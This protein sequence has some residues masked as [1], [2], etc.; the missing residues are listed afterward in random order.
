M[1]SDSQNQETQ[2]KLGLFDAVSIILGIIIGAGIYETPTGIF[3]MMGDPWMTLGLWA[4]C[5]FLALIGAL[6]YAELAT[7]Y[8]RD[9]G[10]YVYITRAYGPLAGYLFGWAQLAVIQT[11]SIGLMAYVFA[12]YASR[13]YKLDELLGEEFAPYTSAIYAGSAILFMTFLNILGV[14]LGKLAQNLLTLAK[15]IGLGAIIVAG[16]AYADT[17]QMVTQG[18]VKEINGDRIVLEI[19]PEADATTFTLTDKTQFYVDFKADK[20]EKRK[21]VDPDSLDVEKKVKVPITYKDFLPVPAKDKDQSAEMKT[22]K[23]LSRTATAGEAFQV[24]T[25]SVGTPPTFLITLSLVLV[26]LTYGGWNDTA[27]VAAEVRN[28]SRNIPIA[29]IIGTAGVTLIYLL[30]NYAYIHGLGFERAQVSREVAA[31]VLKLLPWEFG[32]KAMCI[33]VMVSALGAV[34]GLIFTSS[35]IYA[36]MGKDYSLFAPLGQWNRTLGTPVMSLL[37]QMLIGVT[38][39]A[40][41]G[42]DEGQRCMNKL[43]DFVLGPGDHLDWTGQNGFN[44]LLRCTAPIFWIFFL[45][46]GMAL[47]TLRVNDSHLPRPFRVPLFPITPLIFCATCGYMFY[48]GINFAGKFGLVG[49][50][51]VAA[52]LPFFVF[53][54]RS[55]VSQSQLAGSSADKIN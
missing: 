36:T 33:L 35:R 27:F 40:A 21:N 7:A 47:F 30:V 43:V 4:G 31:D 11:G 55:A 34:N 8:P 12:D 6:C 14:V 45:M 44:S 2:S 18:K 54:R 50:L 32:E 52:G 42:T 53:S 26:F 49:E 39:V 15:V 5:G 46:T 23:I 9:G 28:R 25:V 13:L 41:V 3:R 51:L 29:L 16:F 48:S 22:V 24:M 20:E 10:D 37:L 38:M 17:D 19:D 1:A